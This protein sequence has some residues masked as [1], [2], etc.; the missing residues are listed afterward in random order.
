MQ[1]SP[2]PSGAELLALERQSRAHGSGVGLSELVGCW[3]LE[4]L[5]SK[6]EAKPLGGPAALLR[7]LQASLTIATAS[8]SP[9]LQSGQPVSVHNSVQL[10]PL[11]LQFRGHG[12]LQGKRPLLQFWFEELEVRL[13]QRAIWRQPINRRPQP[14]RLPFFALIGCQ[15]NWLAARGRGGGVALWRRSAN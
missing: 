4:Q 8:E 7:Q 10:G 14:K 2:A 13:G 1:T 6:A 5:W 15:A 3:R 11:Q 12:S 9:P